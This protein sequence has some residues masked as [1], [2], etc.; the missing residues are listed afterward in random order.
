MRLF[1]PIFCCMAFL[2]CAKPFEC[3]KVNGLKEGVSTVQEATSL[4]GKCDDVIAAENGS[5]IFHWRFTSHVYTGGGSIS[6]V[7]L[8]FGA[9]GKLQAKRCATQVR[10][11][12]VKE[13][14][15]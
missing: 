11:P 4:L 15:G 14:A 2:A 5:R 7:S 1:V 3:D 10:G 12:L 9:D 6:D 8:T 13:P